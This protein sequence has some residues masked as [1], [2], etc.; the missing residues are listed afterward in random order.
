VDRG[1]THL[2]VTLVIRVVWAV[3]GGIGLGLRVRWWSRLPLLTTHEGGRR[4]AVRLPRLA[5]LDSLR[6]PVDDG[7]IS[8]IKHYIPSLPVVRTPW[9]IMSLVP[10]QRCVDGTQK[11]VKIGI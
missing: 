10:I 9:N 6:A 11:Q 5:L 3:V 2:L 4:M 1:S 8:N 7:L